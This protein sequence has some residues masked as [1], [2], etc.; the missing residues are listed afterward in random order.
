MAIVRERFNEASE[1][2]SRGE[3]LPNALH[4]DIATTRGLRAL[5]TMRQGRY[6]EAE[7]NFQLALAE[8]ELA[9]QQDSPEAFTELWNLGGLYMK[10]GRIAEAVSLFQ[11]GLRVSE[12]APLDPVMKV[13]TLLALGVSYAK[14]SNR[15]M[16]TNS[17]DRA[18]SLVGSLP[19]GFRLPLGRSLYYQYARFLRNVGHKQRAKSIDAAGERLFGKDRSGMTVALDS[20]FPKSRKH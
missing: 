16:A 4:R 14:L 15:E 7:K 5:L 13:G 18:T 8:R 3:K 6:E 19:P 1:L 12:A 10:E 2:I 9:G 17:F 20:L 11:R